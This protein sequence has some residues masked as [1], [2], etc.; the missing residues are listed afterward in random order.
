MFAEAQA[1]N[2]SSAER[3]VAFG[4][5]MTGGRSVSGEAVV[6]LRPRKHRAAKKAKT[7]AKTKTKTAA[8]RRAKKS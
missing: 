8:R 4:L 6:A 1:N 2:V 5:R 7:K 3:P